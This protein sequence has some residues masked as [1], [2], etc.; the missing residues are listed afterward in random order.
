MHIHVT[1]LRHESY[2]VTDYTCT[3]DLT[4]DDRENKRQKHTKITKKTGSKM[5]CLGS[6]DLTADS[7]KC[8][9]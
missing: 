8:V 2:L 5:H 9:P 4:H 6:Y 1:H 7:Q 3:D